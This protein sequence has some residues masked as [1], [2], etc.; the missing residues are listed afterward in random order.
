MRFIFPTFYAD[1]I[2]GRIFDL[3]SAVPLIIFTSFVLTVYYFLWYV[4]IQSFYGFKG[5]LARS[6]LLFFISAITGANPLYIVEQN[7][8][9]N[10]NIYYDDDA[11][12]NISSVPD[13]PMSVVNFQR[14]V[15][16][17]L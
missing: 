6:F 12:A 7:Q 10:Q 3:V 13:L 8:M 17:I 5:F 9:Q 2:A 11:T 1:A 16:F 4:M 15:S 14:V